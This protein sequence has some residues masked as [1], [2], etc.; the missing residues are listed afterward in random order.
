M[1]KGRTREHFADL[2]QFCENDIQVAD[3]KACIE[4]GS[5]NQA[6]K[7]LGKARRTID[8]TIDRIEKRAIARGWS[9]EHGWTEVVPEGYHIKGVSTLHK[10]E[11]GIQWVKSDKDKEDQERAFKDFVEG[12]CSTIKQVKPTQAIKKRLE[13]DLMSTIIIGDAHLGMYAWHDETGSD[14]FD[15]DIAVAQLMKAIDYLVDHAPEAEE[16]MLVDVG[17][18]MHIDDFSSTTPSNRNALDSDTRYPRILKMAGMVMRYAIDKMLTKHRRVKV[19]VAKGN[20]NPSSSVAL[21]LMLAFYY[22]KEPRV[23]VLETIGH[24]HYIEFG[25]H[26]I[27]VNHGDKIK[28]QKLVSVMARDKPQEWGRTQFRR[29]WTGH[30]HHKVA[31]EIDGCTV[32]AFNTLA[33]RDAWHSG[34]GYGASQSMEMITLHKTEGTHSRL[35]YEL[36]RERA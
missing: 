29:W 34:A 31:E 16:G 32:E 18:F 14:D 23:E 15:T 1:P 19:V 25:Q 3:V 10:T 5:C 12:I 13:K 28:A 20:H 11:D 24:F 22:D 8:V 2:L 21:S 26:L 4:H 7:A 9:P 33:P 17:D 36:L 35:I 30:V 27:G 6:S